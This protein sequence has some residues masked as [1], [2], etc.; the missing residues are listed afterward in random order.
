MSN[1][2]SNVLVKPRPS[3]PILFYTNAI[4]GHSHRV[5]LFLSVLGLEFDKLNV[6]LSKGEQKTS[7]FMQKNKLGQVPVID[8]SGIVVADS[9]AILVYLAL[10]Y[11]S[12]QWLPIDPIGASQVQ[13]FLSIAAGEVAHGL[14]VARIIHMFKRDLDLKRALML[15]EKALLFFEEALSQQTFLIGNLPSIADIANYTYVV[16]APEGGISLEP[17]PKVK[18]WLLKIEQLPGFVPMKFSTVGLRV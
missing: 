2:E 8:D 12:E 5:E 6:D 10:K 1:V 15:G 14:A 17:Y 9:N 7:E 11:G 18:N 16:L 4:S 3:K 13:R